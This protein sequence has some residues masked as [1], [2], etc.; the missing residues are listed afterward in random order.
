MVKFT[1]CQL[2]SDYSGWPEGQ[3]YVYVEPKLDGYRLTA[4]VSNL[5]DVQFFCR[6]AESPEW[7]ENLGHIAEELKALYDEY[8]KRGSSL[9]MG[10]VLDGELDAGTWG[11]TSSLV[12]RK[13]SLASDADKQEMRD[14]L[15]FHIFDW[16]PLNHETEV[17]R[18]PRRRTDSLVNTCPLSTRRAVLDQIMDVYSEMDNN[19]SLVK[20]PYVIAFNGW[21]V[22][23]QHLIYEAEYE[24]SMVKLPGAGYSYNDRTNWWLKIKP[25]KTVEMRIVDSAVGYGKHAGRLGA[26]ICE[27]TKG[28][29]V[30]VGGGF[31]DEE[32]AKFW[33]LRNHMVGQIIEVKIQGGKSFGVA[34]HPV[35][36]RLR[37]DRVGL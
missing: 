10:V 23:N 4:V 35:F 31:T 2:A 11:K 16:V 18:L 8:A 36:M 13:R 19:G 17:Q 27:D 22:D 14:H 6:G 34:R 1:G 9:M 32:R 33:S 15:K 12:R 20:V 28:R 24:G 26:F 7:A 37:H 30:R 21:E 3:E 29:S 25:M 5:G